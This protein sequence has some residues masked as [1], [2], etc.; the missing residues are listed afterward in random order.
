MNHSEQQA[1]E[2]APVVYAM[3]EA[4]KRIDPKKVDATAEFMKATMSQTGTP[5]PMGFLMYE[6]LALLSVLGHRGVEQA[7]AKGLD[8]N[9]MALHA[10]NLV[11][12][13]IG[14]MCKVI[15]DAASKWEKDGADPSKRIVDYL[16]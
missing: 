1:I 14:M 8:E 3:A 4:A 13:Q 15:V 5:D 11:G 2:A 9:G 10:S 12:E 6:V 16:G 7:R